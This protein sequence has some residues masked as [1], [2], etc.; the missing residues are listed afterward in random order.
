[1]KKGIYKLVLV[2]VLLVLAV[3]SCRKA[4][5]WLVKSDDIQHADAMIM[6]MGRIPDR[7]LHISDLYQEDVAGEVWIVEEGSGSK[8]M[9]EERGVYIISTTEQVYGA[10]RDLG[11]AEESIVILP[12]GATSTQMEAEITRDY[13]ATRAGTGQTV[14]NQAVTN[15][16]GTNQASTC[17]SGTN[18]A[19]TNQASTGRFGIDQAVMGRSGI[20]TLLVVSSASHTRR[21]H[22]IFSAA[23]KSLDHPVHICCSPSP[24]TDFNAQKWWKDREDIQDVFIEYVKMANFLLF[25]KRHLK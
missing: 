11:I 17:R 14:T 16:A 9:L 10:F 21:A 18:Q 4:G 7:V 5:S 25:E 24:Y 23:V 1:M 13:L 19:G 8:S 20:D 3:G 22:Q 2:I 15:Q 6:L 12:G